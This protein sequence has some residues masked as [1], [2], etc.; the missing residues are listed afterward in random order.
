MNGLSTISANQVYTDDLTVGS[1]TTT[2]GINASTSQ[3]I[4]FGSNAPT[5][6][7]TN[8]TGL[9][10]SAL[11]ATI[12]YKN[13]AN[14]FTALN[15]FTGGIDA[16][17]NQT[18]NFG[19]NAP[20]MSGTNISGVAKLTTNNTYTANNLFTTVYDATST[21]ISNSP[22]GSFSAANSNNNVLIGKNICNY[23]NSTNRIQN[24]CFIGNDIAINASNIRYNVAIANNALKNLLVGDG[25][26]A[27]GLNSLFGL[28]NGAANIAFGNQTLFNH[29]LGSFNFVAGSANGAN[30]ATPTTSSIPCSYNLLMG[31][32]NISFANNVS[33]NRTIC[34]R[35]IAMGFAALS[36]V[37]AS[38][39]DSIQLTSNVAI[40]CEALG[41]GDGGAAYIGIYGTANTAVGDLAGFHCCGTSAEC[42]FVGAYTDVASQSTTYYRACCIGAG[43]VATASNSINIGTISETTFIPGGLEVTGQATFLTAPNMDGGSIAPGSIQDNALASSIV[44]LTTNN[45]FT[46][47]NTY[48]NDVTFNRTVTFRDGA[49]TTSMRPS[50]QNPMWFYY[51]KVNPFP[52]V[53]RYYFRDAAEVGSD[54]ITFDV[55]T[56]VKYYMV[57][58]GGGGAGNIS[59]GA[60]A[61]GGGGS[62]QLISGTFTALAGVTY[63]LNT[64]GTGTSG[65]SAG[66][67]TS[68]GIGGNGSNVN[69]S[70]AGSGIILIA[71]G[72]L[73][74]FDHTSTSRAGAGGTCAGLGA[75]LGGLT[76]G[77]SGAAGTVGGGGGGSFNT[78]VNAAGGTNTVT[79][80]DGTVITIYGGAGG[81]N[82]DTASGISATLWG[83][84]GGG[85]GGL[86]TQAGGN[87][88]QGFIILETDPYAYET[89]NYRPTYGI[90]PT[91][92]ANNKLLAT[93]E[94]VKNQYALNNTF[95]NLVQVAVP[96]LVTPTTSTTGANGAIQIVC[97]TGNAS[98]AR[99]G[100]SIKA[101]NNANSIINFTNVLGATRGSINGVSGTAV[102]YSTMSDER[103]KENIVNMPS[104]LENIKALSARAFH[105]KSTGES[106]KGFIAQEVYRI[107]PE[108]NQLRNNDKYEDKLYP[109]K[110][111]GSDFIHMIDYG[112]MTPY[113]WSAVQELTLTVERQQKQIDELVGYIN[114]A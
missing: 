25:N 43:S 110:S 77:T 102:S 109:V 45:V 16:S 105:W 54:D 23:Q 20:T 35:N 59:T 48:N 89:Y 31:G 66:S 28:Q 1:L 6:S 22:Y 12:A 94:Y 56:V 13:V 21:N 42:T 100:I 34:N 7:G 30:C 74:A 104:Q 112:K 40:G 98:V 91:V 68:V 11:P 72:G 37:R 49:T 15:T 67:A 51:P 83:G 87:G 75:G 3:V 2:T 93:T 62:G 4:N 88:Y 114:S 73:G 10:T 90:T 64:Y 106:D 47:Q 26:I 53:K 78:A 81:S 5:M 38:T 27:L 95:T 50:Y 65:G 101:S 36:S 99:D 29:T 39:D 17:A 55:D 52:L 69:I 33:P 108:L 92:Y 82:V 80:T 46:G 60:R 86:A 19:T 18:I 107:Y 24:N 111:D 103:L 85:G 76:N 9:P 96:E 113:L 71:A 97:T 44:K 32:G 84:G 63:T 41:G 61:G 70:T 58:N 14:T 57:G 79:M 8:I